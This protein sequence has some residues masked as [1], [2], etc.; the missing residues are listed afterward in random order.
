MK[1]Q[2]NFSGDPGKEISYTPKEEILFDKFTEIVDLKKF[3]KLRDRL[4]IS[5]RKKL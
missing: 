2:K 1:I 4:D 3:E 5:Q